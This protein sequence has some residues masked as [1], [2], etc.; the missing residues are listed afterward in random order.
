M[1]KEV[2]DPED[3]LTANPT[4]LVDLE[5]NEILIKP[6][7]LLY[8]LNKYKKYL[9]ALHLENKA[10]PLLGWKEWAITEVHF[11]KKFIQ[12]KE[13]SFSYQNIVS[14]FNMYENYRNMHYTGHLPIKEQAKIILAETFGLEV[15]PKAGE[16]FL[17]FDYLW[18]AY[19]KI[20]KL[21]D[22][23]Q[24]KNS[25][26]Y[27]LV[28]MKVDLKN[29]PSAHGLVLMEEAAWEMELDYLQE[30]WEE[31][32]D[33]IHNEIE[34]EQNNFWHLKNGEMEDVFNC[35]SHKVISKNQYEN[36]VLLGF[37]EEYLGDFTYPTDLTK[38][39]QNG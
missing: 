32:E 16:V 29:A 39:P 15:E 19:C 38:T 26:R 27:V 30:T 36:L 21:E 11:W 9:E 14:M 31:S 37:N 25:T 13:G 17:D 34:F 3:W 24:V 4:T 6:N 2:L 35:Y 20:F 1:A 12:Q 28:S 18:K 8:I 10:K 22:H 33:N 5:A 23:E 7:N